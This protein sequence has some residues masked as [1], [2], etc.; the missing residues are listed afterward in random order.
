MWDT[1]E[2]AEARV[3]GM[4]LSREDQVKFAQKYQSGKESLAAAS[5]GPQDPF[6]DYGSEIGDWIEVETED[7]DIQDWL[8]V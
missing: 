2:E 1:A 7:R 5:E 6:G 8:E 3:G 4:E